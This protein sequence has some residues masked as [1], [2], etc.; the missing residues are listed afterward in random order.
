M[1]E[2]EYHKRYN[3]YFPETLGWGQSLTTN[4]SMK[5]RLET[6]IKLNLY[7]EEGAPLIAPQ[8]KYKP[9]VHFLQFEAIHSKFTASFPLL[10]K[11][12]WKYKRQKYMKFEDWTICDFD[13]CLKGNPLVE[14]RAPDNEE[15]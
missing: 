13:N 12:F 2:Q 15:K 10:V 9:E 11:Q 5:I 14:Q 3:V 8:D 1:C 6:N 4:V 7:T